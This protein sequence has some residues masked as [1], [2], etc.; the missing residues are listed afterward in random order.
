M[1]APMQPNGQLAMDTESTAVDIWWSA[2]EGMQFR[3]SLLK[4]LQHACIC[5]LYVGIILA[6][7]QNMVNE[8][9]CVYA[10]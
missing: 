4:Q 2:V 6:K 7:Q 5:M 1:Q 8:K 9:T 10:A 3:V